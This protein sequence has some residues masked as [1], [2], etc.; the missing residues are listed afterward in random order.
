ME[1]VAEYAGL[2]AAAFLS[3]TVLPFQSEV[4]LFG[5]LLTEHDQWWLLVLVASVG[6]TLGSAVNWLLGRFIAQLEDRRW[7]PVRR[8]TVAKAEKWYRRYGRWSLLL[9][10][11]PFIGDPLTVVA[12]VLREPFPVFLALVALAKTARYFAVAAITFGWF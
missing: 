5:L 11:L 12:G 6:N 9:S 1:H 7:F 2:F 8:E 4:V 10:W 3:A